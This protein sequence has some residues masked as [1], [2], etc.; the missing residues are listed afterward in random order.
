MFRVFRPRIFVRLR[1]AI[2][3]SL[4]RH[5]RP[6]AER[7]G[8]LL[9][10][11]G[12]LGDN[13]LLSRALTC[14][15][16]LARPGERVSLLIRSDAAAVSFLFPTSIEVRTYEW[17]RFQR[18]IFYRWRLSYALHR[19]GLRLVVSTDYDRH[20]FVDDH[21]VA[22][23]GAES[24]AE[25]A[26]PSKKLGPYLAANHR[27]FTRL[28][29]PG[30]EPAHR[31]IRLVR[32]A[33]WAN[34]REMSVPPLAEIRHA[35]RRTPMLVVLHPFASDVRKNVKPEV[36]LAVM[37]ALPNDAR[38]VLSA[39][40][41]DL[42]RCPEYRALLDDP[43]VTLDQSSLQEKFHGLL[44][45]ANAVV[46][47]DTVLAHLAIVAGAPTLCVASAAYVGWA[48]PYD[49]RMSAPHARFVAL[50]IACAGC[51]GACSYP[52]EDGRFRCVAGH[53]EQH[54]VS[55][56]NALTGDLMQCA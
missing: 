45:Q 40:P 36:F 8:V 42:K 20:P 55:E 21:L 10:A 23:T 32:L 19:Q 9:I 4:L 5:L 24:I 25:T 46:S 50:P 54:V 53:A 6:P 43:R 11:S 3:L 31:Y 49:R 56:L 33:R 1:A 38:I 37:R 22:A 35:P 16:T 52:L 47:V 51:L 27:L 44:R 48:I 29:A 34:G 18:S 14:F 41:G 12:G 13:V 26:R 30:H 39:A 2:V 15:E 7:S 28:F 17:R